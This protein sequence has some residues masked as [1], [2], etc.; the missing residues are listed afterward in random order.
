MERL[1]WLTRQIRFLTVD[2]WRAIDE[3]FTGRRHFWGRTVIALLASTAVLLVAQFFCMSDFILD[4]PGARKLFSSLPYPRLYP[5]LYWALATALNY[6]LLPVIVIKLVYREKLSDFGFAGITDMKWLLPYAAIF[7]ATVPWIYAASLS[8]AFLQKYPFY[9]QAADSWPQLLVWE[10]AYGVQFLALE[11]FFRG[12]LLFA[13]ARSIGSQ[14][15]FVM[16]MPY[17]MLH[18]NKPLFEAFSAALAGIVLGTLALRT[19][20]IY[21][22][23]MIH[24]AVA[25]SMDLLSLYHQGLLRQLSRL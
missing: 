25:W 24:V 2:Q 9:T 8:P 7:L 11:F 18:F 19:R 13:L 12:F 15:I 21:G 6:L 23:V 5:Q 14:A 22:G 10:G 16:V 17:V 1:P 3:Q 4:V 20:S